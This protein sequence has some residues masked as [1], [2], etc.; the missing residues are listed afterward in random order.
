[1]RAPAPSDSLEPDPELSCPRPGSPRGPPRQR[2]VRDGLALLAAT[3][4]PRSG[5]YCDANC[6]AYPYTDA[7]AF[8]PRDYVWM[9][10]TLLMVIALAMLAV[11]LHE[12]VPR[13]GASTAEPACH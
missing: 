9:Y 2:R 7:S 13:P 12:I 10:P 6:V 1:M 5:P 8:V 11:G 3:T 4:P